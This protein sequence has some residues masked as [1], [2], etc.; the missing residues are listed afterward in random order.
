VVNALICAIVLAVAAVALLTGAAVDAAQASTAVP[1]QLRL[2]ECEGHCGGLTRH[3]S[4]GD[5]TATCTGCG[6]PRTA[7]TDGA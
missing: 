3:E 4:D 7:A 6:T 1:G 2:I 5:G